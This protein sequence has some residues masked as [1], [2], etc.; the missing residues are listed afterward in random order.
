MQRSKRNE[1][2]RI[3]CKSFNSSC[4]RKFKTTT[5]EKPIPS[6]NII[7]ASVIMDEVIDFIG[8]TD[9]QSI[10]ESTNLMMSCIQKIEALRVQFRT[11]YRM[12]RIELGDE[13]FQA[14]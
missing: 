11:Q 9:P 13:D 2:K 7:K 1:G 5:D 3:D 12:L 14:E 10:K 4:E 6:E 8:D